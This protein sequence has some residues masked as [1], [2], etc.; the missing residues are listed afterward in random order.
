MGIAQYE[1]IAM[2]LSTRGINTQGA[3]KLTAKVEM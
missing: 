2:P 3:Q 1:N